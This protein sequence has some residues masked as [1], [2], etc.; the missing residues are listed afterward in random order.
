MVV[1]CRCW[2]SRPVGSAPKAGPVAVPGPW[3]SAEPE[4]G[5]RSRPGGPDLRAAASA[6]QPLRQRCVMPV[7]GARQGW[8]YGSNFCFAKDTESCAATA[9]K[10]YVRIR[11]RASQFD[12]ITGGTLAKHKRRLRGRPLPRFMLASYAPIVT[13]NTQ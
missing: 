13:Q 9:P 6:P 1:L 4:P 11:C 10:Q 12:I 2:A 7:I 3:R 5:S 8:D